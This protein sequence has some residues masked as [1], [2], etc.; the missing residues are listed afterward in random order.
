MPFL[1]DVQ[2]SRLSPAS[3]AGLDLWQSIESA[4]AFEVS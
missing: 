4:D 2:S 1:R 3:E